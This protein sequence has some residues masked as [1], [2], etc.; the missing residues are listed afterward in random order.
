MSRSGDYCYIL[1]GS[2]ATNGT[3]VNPC[4]PCGLGSKLLQLEDSR[5]YDE[6]L[7]SD[8]SSSVSS[9]GM[10]AAPITVP[11]PVFLPNNK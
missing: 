11:T 1:T 6:S 2:D 3:D 8:Y 10:T 5:M 9:C 4:G 7:A